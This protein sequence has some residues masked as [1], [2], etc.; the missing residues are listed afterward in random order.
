[1]K[2]R[3]HPRIPQTP[4]HTRMKPQRV[5]ILAAT[6]AEIWKTTRVMDLTR[7]QGY[8]HGRFAGCDVLTLVTGMGER[9]MTE[10]LRKHLDEASETYDWLLHAGFSGAL[11]PTLHVGDLVLPGALLRTAGGRLD[12]AGGDAAQTLVTTDEIITSPQ[13]KR[14][15]FEQTQA[16]AVDMESFAVARLAA[17]AG[18]AYTAVRAI[19]DDAATALPAAAA[20]WITDDGLPRIKAPVVWALTGW[21]RLGRLRQ[22]AKDSGVAA[23]ALAKVLPDMV[24]SWADSQVKEPGA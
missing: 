15:L 24:R 23:N 11:R 1:M 22:L 20:D 14:Q 19:S 13:H 9:R 8:S 7:E 10:R 6:W 4:Y 18:L 12:V 17:E 5:L 3:L 21:G 2:V 16:D